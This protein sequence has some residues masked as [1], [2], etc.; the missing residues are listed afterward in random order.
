MLLWQLERCIHL[1]VVHPAVAWP[2]CVLPVTTGV[3]T[4]CH[5]LP[6][7]CLSI[8]MLSVER[9]A[10]LQDRPWPASPSLHVTKQQSCKWAELQPAHR[11]PP[12][13]CGQGTEVTCCDADMSA[14]AQ[15]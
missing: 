2:C 9:A 8:M 1:T 12:P 13:Q 5:D 3:C 4:R 14:R 7:T 11:F 15:L 10:C 6:C